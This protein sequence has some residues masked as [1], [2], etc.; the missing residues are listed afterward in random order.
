MDNEL[1]MKLVR[2]E[3]ECKREFV[4]KAESL[5]EV[6]QKFDGKVFNKRLET[7]M[8]EV[9]PI[10][11][12]QEYFWK[13]ISITGWIPDRMVQSD[14]VDKWGYHK[15]AYIK[16]DRI[17]VGIIRDAFDDDKRIIAETIIKAIRSTAEYYKESADKLEEQLGRIEEIIAERDR[18]YAEKQRFLHNTSGTLR[19]Y[20][21]LEV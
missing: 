16:D 7:A 20:F 6:V 4:S 19:E 10:R 12:E 13:S 11:V 8:K 18:I 1:A 5:C 21:G 9:Y 17:Y 14:S 3:I 15:T 2:K